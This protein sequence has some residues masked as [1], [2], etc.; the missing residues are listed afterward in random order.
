MKEAWKRRTRQC[1]NKRFIPPPDPTVSPLCQRENERRLAGCRVQFMQS[2]QVF[3][4]RAGIV[5][6]GMRKRERR[7][8]CQ[9]LGMSRGAGVPTAG[10]MRQLEGCGRDC[11]TCM[12]VPSDTT[13][14]PSRRNRLRVRTRLL[15]LFA[16]QAFRIV[17]KWLAQT[18]EGTIVH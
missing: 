4:C 14:Q 10:H 17:C 2:S 16:S 13:A 9:T 3:E 18:F 12:V 11:R 7:S 15:R 8:S 6:H 1:D 5:S